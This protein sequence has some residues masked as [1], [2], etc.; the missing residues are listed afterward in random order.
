MDKRQQE[1]LYSQIGGEMGR[2][3]MKL[4]FRILLRYYQGKIKSD[5]DRELSSIIDCL[6]FINDTLTNKINK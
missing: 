5:Y 1:Q 2:R 6:Q 3:G 4:I